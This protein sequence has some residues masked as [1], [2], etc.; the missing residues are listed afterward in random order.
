MY[1]KLVDVGDVLETGVCKIE[2]QNVSKYKCIYMY[3][4][5]FQ[6][7]LTYRWLS[8]EACSLSVLSYN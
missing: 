4:Y 7:E 3:K 2:I 5:E 8:W 6:M 1:N